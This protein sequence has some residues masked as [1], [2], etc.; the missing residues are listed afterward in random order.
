MEIISSESHG[1]K[2]TFASITGLYGRL[3]PIAAD[4]WL[5]IRQGICLSSVR[6]LQWGWSSEMVKITMFV[7][8][9][10]SRFAPSQWETALLCNDVSHWLGAN[11]ES[12]LVY[13]LITFLLSLYQIQFDSSSLWIYNLKHSSDRYFLCYSF[14]QSQR[15]RAFNLYDM[16]PTIIRGQTLNLKAQ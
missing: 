7:Y 14:L 5:V 1:A 8:R 3:Q 11:L 12:A 6:S 2:I 13:N 15:S 10:D 16:L 9:A 4:Q